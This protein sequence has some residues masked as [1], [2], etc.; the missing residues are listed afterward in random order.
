MNR[1]YTEIRGIME[2]ECFWNEGKWNFGMNLKLDN[3][4]NNIPPAGLKTWNNGQKLK[5][6]QCKKDEFTCHTYGHC[7][8]MNKRCD[9]HPDCPVDGSDENECKLMTLV[10]GYNRKHPPTKNI[11]TSVSM[12]VYDISHIDELDMSYTVTFKLTIK[13]F[14]KRIIFRNLKATDYENQLENLETNEMWTPN[15]YIAYSNNIYMKAQ[16]VNEEI[17]VAV[18]INRNGSPK[19]N[20]LSEIDEDYLYPGNENP[21]TLENYFR[22]KL[23]CKF[24]LQWYALRLQDILFVFTV[25][26]V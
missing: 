26:N 18:T 24:N 9:G 20:E 8:E 13:W 4:T 22:I 3:T 12:T 2:T 14:D 16:Q 19:Q 15:L 6:T 25:L 5:F 10:K 1:K 7:I 11:T 17:Y 21:I 23:D